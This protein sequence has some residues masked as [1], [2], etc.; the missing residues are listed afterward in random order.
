MTSSQDKDVTFR[1]PAIV[2]KRQQ[3][4]F[5]SIQHWLHNA[6]YLHIVLAWV[7]L[8]ILSGALFFMF[9][10]MHDQ[11]AV[12]SGI[13]IEQGRSYFEE[14]IVFSVANAFLLGWKNVSSVGGARIVVVVELFASLLLYGIL[15]SRLFAQ[16]LHLWPSMFDNAKNKKVNTIALMFSIY[17]HDIDAIIHKLSL[18]KSAGPSVP[19]Y[20]AKDLEAASEEFYLGLLEVE[21]FLNPAHTRRVAGHHVLL[22]LNNVQASLE[23]MKELLHAM[24]E[25]RIKYASK[26]FV[27]NLR[28]SL[29]LT[30]KI[31]HHYKNLHNSFGSRADDYLAQIGSLKQ[32]LMDVL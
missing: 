12:V 31:G 19:K 6:T 3:P 9:S 1:Q 16:T 21:M 20:I 27:F 8:I 28:Y 18:S 17:R 23:K 5:F 26:T 2:F 29:D 30:E 4:H 25:Q 7:A 24:S 32:E 14:S 22:L 11:K 15:I 13:G 10:V